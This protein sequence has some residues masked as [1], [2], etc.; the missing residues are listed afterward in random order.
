MTVIG[1]VVSGMPLE[2]YSW[3]VRQHPASAGYPIP[4]PDYHKKEGRITT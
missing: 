3:K 2:V 4:S 1:V